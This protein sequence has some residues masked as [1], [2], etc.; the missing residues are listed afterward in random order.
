M[1]QNL[2]KQRARGCTIEASKQF[3]ETLKQ[4]LTELN[5]LDK[6]GHIWNCDESN[7]MGTFGRKRFFTRKGS[8]SPK[9][10]AADNEKLAYTVLVNFYP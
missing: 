10:L 8:S 1:S 4:K 6:P 7:F 3:Y 2:S 9:V 5:I